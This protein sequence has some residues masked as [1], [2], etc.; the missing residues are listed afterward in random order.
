[1]SLVDMFALTLV[2]ATIVVCHRYPRAVIWALAIAASYFIS[3]WWRRSGGGAPE[4][5]SSLCDSFICLAI[6][7]F[8]VR[9]WE[10]RV[11]FVTVGMLAVNFAYLAGLPFLGLLEYQMALEAL[12]ILALLIISFAGSYKWAGYE[13]GRTF[14]HWG[15]VVGVPRPWRREVARGHEEGE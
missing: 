4:L 11:F 9:I 3:G 5:V 14:D 12:N 8:G 2:C 6:F 1:M 10:M 15:S 13:N 7:F